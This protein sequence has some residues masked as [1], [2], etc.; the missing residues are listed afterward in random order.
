MAVKCALQN[1]FTVS[2][3]IHGVDLNRL[4]NLD[5]QFIS[6]LNCNI[7]MNQRI[8]GIPN[9]FSDI[10]LILSRRFV[11]KTTMVKVASL[12]F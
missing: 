3:S 12:L 2:S 6:S 9:F 4:N 8:K 10:C 5:R 11:T 1:Y 7:E